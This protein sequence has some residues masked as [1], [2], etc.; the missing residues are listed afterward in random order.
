MIGSIITGLAAILLVI[1]FVNILMN[2]NWA[3]FN[4]NVFFI[5][6]LTFAQIAVF[7]IAA[8]VGF[9]YL[10]KKTDSPILI[11]LGVLLVAISIY[12]LISGMS[13]GLT[14]NLINGAILVGAVLYTIGAFQA[15]K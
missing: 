7:V 4:M 10:S 9:K 15:K 3:A 11:V 14:L 1:G 2:A 13:G 6:L 12:S 8:I 5:L